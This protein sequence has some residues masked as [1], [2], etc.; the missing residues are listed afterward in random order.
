MRTISS[1][2]VDVGIST[3]VCAARMPL[4]TRVR[5]S[6][7]G[8]E[9]ELKGLPGR[10]GHAGNHAAVSELTQADTANAELAVNGARATALTAAGVPARLV[11]RRASLP[12]ALRSLSHASCSPS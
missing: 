1:F 5:R 9:K 6:A 4:R 8:S 10:L 11:L 12:H 7:M 3:V 2:T